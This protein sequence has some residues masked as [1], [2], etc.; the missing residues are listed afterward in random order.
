MQQ[1]T[2]IMQFTIVSDT[3]VYNPGQNIWQKCRFVPLP[4]ISMLF[5]PIHVFLREDFPENSNIDI[6]GG[7]S[8]PNN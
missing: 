6:G 7:T 2:M 4:P 8:V 1:Y 5:A 3:G